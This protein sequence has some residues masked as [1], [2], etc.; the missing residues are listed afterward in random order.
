[1]WKLPGPGIKPVCPVLSGGF[2]STAPPGKSIYGYYCYSLY[3]YIVFYCCCN[4]WL[5]NWWLKTAHICYLTVLE[6]KSLRSEGLAELKSRCQQDCFPSGSSRG[7]SISL[8]FAPCGG[9]PHS[10]ACGPSPIFRVSSSGSGPVQI[11]SLWS[12]VVISLCCLPL[13]LSRTMW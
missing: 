13:P 9:C 11:A 3:Y 7:E 5:Q 1:M 4:K 10:S 6:F 12:S 2:L 8:P